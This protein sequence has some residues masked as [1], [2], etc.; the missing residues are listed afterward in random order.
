MDKQ[1]VLCSSR[2]AER[3]GYLVGPAELAWFF[4]GPAEHAPKVRLRYVGPASHRAR[5]RQARFGGRELRRLLWAIFNGDR[6]HLSDYELAVVAEYTQ[7]NPGLFFEAR[8]LWREES[9]SEPRSLDYRAALDTS[10]EI[11]PF[12][13]EY[14]QLACEHATARHRT[15]WSA[16]ASSG[17]SLPSCR[18]SCYRVARP[19]ARGRRSRPAASRSGARADPDLEDDDPPPAGESCTGRRVHRA[20]S[21]YDAT[22]GGVR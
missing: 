1:Q 16:V 10:P 21:R 22:P 4:D 8:K 7:R 18:P 19:R 12:S 11:V 6:E 20:A 5:A 2:A 15:Q 17:Q 3:H 13:P 14:E 9:L